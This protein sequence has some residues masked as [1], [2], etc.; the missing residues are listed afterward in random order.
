MG[1]LMNNK[2]ERMGIKLWPY[3]ARSGKNNGKLGS[4]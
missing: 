4:R 2:S 1:R 3:P